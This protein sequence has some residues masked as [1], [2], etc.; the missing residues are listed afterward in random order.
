[1]RSAL[2]PI[3]RADRPGKVHAGNDAVGREHQIASRR[4][5]DRGR[6]V[7]EAERA[8]MGRERPEIARDQAIFGRFR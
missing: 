6:V 3:C 1:M 4:R 5:R 8:R 2:R 7:G